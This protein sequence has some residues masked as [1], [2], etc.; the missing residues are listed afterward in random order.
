MVEELLFVHKNR[1]AT[2]FNT[3]N[4]PMPRLPLEILL[5]RQQSEIIIPRFLHRICIRLQT[6][7]TD[8]RVSFN[9]YLWLHKCQRASRSDD[10][11]F[12][13]LSMGQAVRVEM[14]IIIEIAPNIGP[15][16][17]KPEYVSV[18]RRVVLTRNCKNKDG[19]L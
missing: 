15:N 12:V 11:G 17:L 19:S 10:Q 8:S 14:T 16:M 3:D 9:T 7:L 1:P 13:G 5:S 2:S 6:R 4:S 18:R